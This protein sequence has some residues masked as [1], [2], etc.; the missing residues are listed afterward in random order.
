MKKKKSPTADLKKR[1]S[2]I[3]V[4]LSSLPCPHGIGDMG[5]SSFRFIDFLAESGQKYWQILPVGPTN[6]IFG[7]S[8]YMSPSAFAGSPLLISP[9]T[10]L[11]EGLLRKQDVDPPVFPEYQVN[12]G[13]VTRWKN[14][15]LKLAWHM[16]KSS[17]D[18]TAL[19]NFCI[20]QPW[21]KDHALFQAL[22][23]KYAQ[24]P[25]YQWQRD[26]R[27][28][29]PVTMAAACQELSDEIN[30][31]IFQQYLFFR[32]WQQLLDYANKRS[33]SL[34][35][36]LPIYVA[37]DS[38][39]VWAN[40]EIFDLDQSSG[41]AN[42]IAGVPPDYFSKTGQRWGNPIYRWGSRK[43]SVQSKLYNW[44]QQRLENSFS[45]VD[46]LRID[47]FRGFESYWAIPAKEKTA[48]KGTWKK[49]P[50]I[51]FFKEMEKRL[52]KLNII[53]EDL[54]EITPEV[55]RLRSDLG[56]PGMKILLFSF[57][58]NPNNN[59][60][61]Y[62]MK[63]NCVV[64]TG[65]HDNDTAV[66]WHLSPEVNPESRHQAKQTANRKNNDASDFHQDMIYLA[67]SSVANISILPMQ[68]VLGFGN[69]C[70]MNTPGTTSGNWQWR[71]SDR[72]ITDEL[73][74]SLKKTT[75]LFGRLNKKNPETPK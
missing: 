17:N 54:G 12:Y 1:S 38:V 30:F 37:L 39:D 59:Y 28:R 51:N 10:L 71:F 24:K 75:T 36:D 2:G 50:G 56:Y 6:P 70:R 32:Q 29:M 15:I 64:Y 55:E 63:K 35:G 31:E 65:T 72:F 49:G 34:I 14:N 46:I 43:K 25:W 69:D 58:G 66:G 5:E 44:W 19:N 3:L 53:A 16:F 48:V 40:R 7:N 47:H 60:L 26:I 42:N 74:A 33:I 41:K 45:M 62:N 4:H 9:E 20:Q 73:T 23:N 27:F 8:P 57:D 68:D 61:P 18:E 13:L 21:V 22:R 11:R 52:G 67:H